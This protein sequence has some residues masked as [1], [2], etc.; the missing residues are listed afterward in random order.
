MESLDEA[1]DGMP[2]MDA[3]ATV[4]QPFDDEGHSAEEAQTCRRES[5]IGPPEAHAL[6]EC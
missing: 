3:D 6:G 1:V 5:R 4:L 2:M